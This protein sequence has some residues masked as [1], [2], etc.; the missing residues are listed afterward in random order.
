VDPAGE[1]CYSGNRGC[2]EAKISGSGVE[3]SFEAW[4]G[5]K[6]VL[7]AFPQKTVQAF[8]ALCERRF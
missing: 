2:V 7:K 6:Y 5:R 3:W 8:E 4:Y 1:L